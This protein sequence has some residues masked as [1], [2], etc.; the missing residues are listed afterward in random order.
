MAAAPTN[1]VRADNT[2]AWE[3]V[4][5]RVEDDLLSGRLKPG[6]HL[7]AERTLAAELSVG[8]SS[9]REAL[10][11]LE[12]MGLIRTQT[13]SGPNAGAIIIARPSG[14]MAA[15]MRLQVA[16]QGFPV[17]D[18]VA[19]RLLLEGAV[20]A[21]LATQ[22]PAADLSVARE[23]LVAMGQPDLTPLEFL[24]LDQQFHRSMAETS[25]NQVMLAMMAGLRSAIEGYVLA[26]ANE[27][28]TWDQTVCRLHEEHTA[29]LTAIEQGEPEEAQRRIQAHITDYYTETAATAAPPAVVPPPH[30]PLTQQRES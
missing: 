20:V 11:V 3:V 24:A 21:T 17:A 22:V 10:R 1:P 12:V 28:T 9:V 23:L 30:P 16:A 29:I 5:E 26:G 13:G 8:R 27:L 19:T 15:L 6:D 18:V 4:L 7:P 14:G 25:G 2:R